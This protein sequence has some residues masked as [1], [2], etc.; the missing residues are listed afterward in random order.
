MS[1]VKTINL[2]NGMLTTMVLK[3]NEIDTLYK[4]TF[5]SIQ[6]LKY[7]Q[8]HMSQTGPK[9]CFVPQNCENTPIL[10]EQSIAC[11]VYT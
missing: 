1:N 8:G 11:N 4:E 3:Y 5:Q 6:K 9:K 10:I 2:Q 7:I